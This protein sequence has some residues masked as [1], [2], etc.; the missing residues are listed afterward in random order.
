MRKI[1]AGL[2]LTSSLA[3]AHPL[4]KMVAERQFY[5][6]LERISGQLKVAR[7]A[8]RRTLLLLQAECQ[9][10][11][12]RLQAAEKT[13]AQIPL[14]SAPPRFFRLRGELNELRENF[15][16]ARQDFQHVLRLSPGGRDEILAACEL[17]ILE[18]R[19]GSN[20]A[21]TLWQHAVEV[22]SRGSEEHSHWNLIY[23]TQAEIL[24]K[25]G[26]L[27]QG[28]CAMR[29]ARAHYQALK[30]VDGVRYCLG[31]EASF[32]QTLGRY[33]EAEQTWVRSV[34]LST[35]GSAAELIRWGYSLVYVR[36]DP[37][38]LRR[39]LSLA[40]QRWQ[41]SWPAYERCHLRLLQ[42]QVCLRALSDL[43]KARKYLD[44]AEPLAS[45]TPRT[46]EHMSVSLRFHEFGDEPTE[47]EIVAWLRLQCLVK[48]GAPPARRE[49]FLRAHL[50]HLR[51]GARAPWLLKLGETLLRQEPD[52]AAKAFE[53]ALAVASREN[54][55]P[56]L[57][58]ILDA[59][60]SSG[61]LR[62]AQPTVV[63]I[64][65][66]LGSADPDESLRLTRS[67]IR[68]SLARQLAWVR[69]LW[70]E[71]LDPG[72]ESY[73]LLLQEELLSDPQRRALL[74][75][76][77]LQR[78]EKAEREK[79]SDTL[80]SVYL[81]QA[82]RLVAEN[83]LSEALIQARRARQVADRDE[84]A[85]RRAQSDRLIA[86]LQFRLGERE[87]ALERVALARA[88]FARLSNSEAPGEEADTAALQVAFQLEMQQP[89]AALKLSEHYLKSDREELQSA[90]HYARAR[91]Y[92][93]SSRPADA[94]RE[95][96]LCEEP[97][98]GTLYQVAVL[99]LRGVA[100]R[101]AAQP[102]SSLHSLQQALS[103]AETLNSLTQ[104]NVCLTWYQMDPQTAPLVATAESL[105]RL[106]AEM[107]PAYA[108]RL[109]ARPSTRQLFE[110]AG[111]P[112]AAATPGTHWLTREE[113][114]GQVNAVLADHADL[115]T[116]VP[117]L[118][119]SLAHRA[120]EMRGDQVALEYYVGRRE[121]VIMLASRDGFQVRRLS[122]ER[123]TIDGWVQ[124]LRQQL[125]GRS[126][127]S[128]AASGLYRMLLS[129]VEEQIRGKEL[130][131]L[132][133]GP[134]LRLPWD[135]LRTPD[136]KLL[137]QQFEWSF[138]AGE[139]TSAGEATVGVPRVVAVGGV[140]GADLPATE[141]EVQQLGRAFPSTVRTLTGA[142]ATLTELK[143]LLPEADVLHIATHSQVENRPSDSFIQLS[144]GFLRLDQVYGLPL[145]PG[146]LV[147]LSSC[148]SASPQNQERG[149][150]TLAGAFLAAG[151]SGVIASLS[152]VGDEEAQA[153]FQEFYRNLAKGLSP[154][155]SL[156][157]AKETRLESAG[158]SDW[159]S[160]V[161]L[162]GG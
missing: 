93:M 75:K 48:E 14:G 122:V 160:F 65:D 143:R 10:G 144:D 54:Q 62:R 56:L 145:R 28:L 68:S 7:P 152:P 138:W 30:D 15:P 112:V 91:A 136:G 13:L 147:V 21:E 146:G 118:P 52:R 148:N 77:D 114:F 32:L 1:L 45:P 8:E 23:R 2:L 129:P 151:A 59:Y 97:V 113:F 80:T 154:A 135:L 43:P 76:S 103:L 57:R 89:E 20:R 156:R 16:L 115:M 87:Q 137:A 34:R 5:K 120:Q 18:A 126:G 31:E 128:S 155:L 66:F 81:E 69:P 19:E 36:D 124:E 82:L 29:L 27:E 84:L 39:W 117:L 67:L 134:L 96:E 123:Q 130:L 133:H 111:R 53:A 71:S 102:E 110:L 24:R 127:S 141:R 83:R 107:P 22:A 35:R 9:L 46:G 3:F 51:G 101:Q 17:A 131:V 86:Y 25:N 109:K 139:S 63:R 78:L 158:E 121:L 11:L 116:T 61:Q 149:P 105:D 140:L 79:D 42:A 70:A 159:A 47:T 58:N 41:E 100:Y 44:L 161:L 73:H 90:F 6:A 33:S 4:D 55:V 125:E 38:A 98:R 108:A 104:R 88:A 49:Q 12:Q 85:R 132:A 162:S 26:D 99:T 119:V 72:G 60:L 94:L 157:K 50:S 95:L 106:F 37:G 153:L 92:L 142:Q 64:R 74:E 40:D 150:V